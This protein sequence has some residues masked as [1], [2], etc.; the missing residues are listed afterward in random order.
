LFT[1]V[2]SKRKGIKMACQ[3]CKSER[4][5]SVNAKCSDLCFVSIGNQE[6]DDYVPDDMGIGGGDYVEFEL[7]LDCGQV[8]GNFPLEKSKLESVDPLEE[9]Y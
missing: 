6:K 9:D 4:I 1:I 2:K 3:K 7:C 8:Q 5:L